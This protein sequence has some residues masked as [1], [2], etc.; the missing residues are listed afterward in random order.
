MKVLAKNIQE[1]SPWNKG[2]FTKGPEKRITRK[3]SPKKSH[4]DTE[5]SL[6]TF[7]KIRSNIYREFI[8]TFIIIIIIIFYTTSLE[9]YSQ[10]SASGKKTG[11]TEMNSKTFVLRLSMS[12][13]IK[14]FVS[15]TSSERSDTRR[16][17]IYSPIAMYT[18]F[19]REVE[20]RST[21][22]TTRSVNSDKRDP[23]IVRLYRDFSAISSTQQ[24]WP[25]LSFT[26]FSSFCVRILHK[27]IC[28]F[29][30]ILEKSSWKNCISTG[31]CNI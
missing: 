14:N 6:K 27:E 19:E 12:V 7:S 13:S 11:G 5:F 9:E 15:V 10:V 3:K 18:Y 20:T 17:I 24:W 2:S 29:S 26:F 25:T 16:W 1:K 4:T 8:V 23:L 28:E 21:R 31:K 30:V 22:F